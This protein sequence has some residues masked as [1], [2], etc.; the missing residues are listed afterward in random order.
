MLAFINAVPVLS[1]SSKAL[2][3]TVFISPQKR[4]ESLRTTFPYVVTRAT[5]KS[6]LNGPNIHT[7]TAQTRGQVS[8]ITTLED[9]WHLADDSKTIAQYDA[10]GCIAFL[11]DASIEEIRSVCVQYR[12]FVER[13]P[14]NLATVLRKLP[15]I[16]FKSLLSSMLSEE[17]GSGSISGAHIGWYDRFLRS[18]GVTDY[19]LEH[20]LYDENKEILLEID[21][22][23]DTKSYEHGVGLVGMAGECLCQIY[24]TAMHKYL[25]QNV[26][27]QALGNQVDWEFWTFHI[28]EDDIEH[29][30]LVRECINEMV[31]KESG[32]RD[33]ATGYSFGKKKWDMFW[34]NNFK[35]TR[36]MRN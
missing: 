21:Y 4:E 15:N 8:D 34:Y 31:M 18:I 29:R 9:F 30:R 22:R 16:Q 25:T 20:S 10:D 3:P 19:D 32:V 26:H 1:S 24:L 13:Y 23:C 35:N 33:L 11:K 36:A 12:Y 14:D 27:V 6:S 5:I 7:K 28:G 2:L 17:L